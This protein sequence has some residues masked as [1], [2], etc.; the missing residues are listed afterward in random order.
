MHQAFKADMD[1]KSRRQIFILSLT[2]VLHQ[3][4]MSR[5]GSRYV[6]YL[7]SFCDISR[8]ITVSEVVKGFLYLVT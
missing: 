6:N 3:V 7:T 5:Q 1:F 2:Y 8:A 4:V